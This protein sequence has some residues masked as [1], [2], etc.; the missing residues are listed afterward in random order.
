MSSG[1]K[2]IVACM[3]DEALFVVEWVAHHLT[4]GFDRIIV[5]TNDCRDGTARLLEAISAHLPVEHYDNPGPYEAGTIQKQA[6]QKAF[7]LPQVR[8]A[9]WVMHID[10]DEY[11]N[12]E[13][14]NRRIDDLLALHPSSDVIAIMWRHFGSAGL[15]T[16][17]GGSVLETFTRCE[18]Q[19][20]DPEAGGFTAF[21]SIFRPQ[22]FKMISV[23]SPKLPVGDLPVVAVNTIGT[24]LD[25]H[26]MLHIR[27]SGFR[28]TKDNVTWENASLHHH[29]VKSD[30]LHLL[31]FARGDADG[32]KNR[33]R[34]IGSE[35]YNLSNR[36]DVEC[37]TILAYRP[38]AREIEAKLRADP[39]ITDIEGNAFDWFRRKFQ[40]RVLSEQ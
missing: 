7:E 16:W 10:A 24:N 9:D 12:V 13:V 1:E 30:D 15:K 17:E 38:S 11:L 37:T 6:L 27:G 20:P 14:G 18:A 28:A 19:L 23:H 5:F 29:H 34:R 22:R 32:R 31:K 2:V 4:L 25:P 35:F 39:E 33:K 21:K 26:P 36:N 40:S 8:D 3:R